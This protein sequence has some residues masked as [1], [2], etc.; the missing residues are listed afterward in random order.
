MHQ[1]PIT[2]LLNKLF[3]GA[4]TALLTA[5]GIHPAHPATPITN[6]FA[7][8][9]FVA[10]LLVGFWVAA[11]ASLSVEKPGTLQHI[12]ETVYGLMDAQ[13]EEIIGHDHRRYLSYLITLGSFI[14]LCNLL[15]LVPYFE[16]P[17]GDKVVPLGCAI[18]TWCFYQM[19]GFRA[20][21]IG[22][23]KHF[24]GPVWWMAPLMILIE[25]CSHLA[26]M[27]S[28]TVRLYANMFAGDL[29]TLVMFSLFP[30][31]WPVLFLGLHAFVALIQT[32]IFVLLPMV[33]IGEATAQESH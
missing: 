23:L 29:V 16:T 27:L 13:S 24:A 18:V 4:V 22:Y 19:H 6:A 33:Y 1:L 2:A 11:R 32:A 26:R 12:I 9:I 14:L 3:G 15:G 10:L 25:V 31:V 8:E 28:L 5:L 30:V 17:T 21:G 20:N 7:M